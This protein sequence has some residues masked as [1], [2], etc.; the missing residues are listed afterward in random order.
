[1]RDE[2]CLI[3]NPLLKFHRGSQLAESRTMHQPSRVVTQT[4]DQ[5]CPN[6]TYLRWDLV[7]AGH[8]HRHGQNSDLVADVV[9]LAL[10]RH[11]EGKPT[12]PN[13]SF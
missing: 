11:E 4:L 2:A 13:A 8:G 9:R 10:A 5:P 3:T 12:N 7:F 6:R 1:M